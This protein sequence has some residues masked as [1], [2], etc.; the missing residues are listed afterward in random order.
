VFISK[1][2][3]LYPKNPVEPGL[4]FCIL[5]VVHCKINTP[6]STTLFRP[7]EQWNL[8]CCIILRK[9]R[10]RRPADLLSIVV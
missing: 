8:E 4:M 10:A 6:G 5:G 7:A 3:C 2:W 9:G 1:Y